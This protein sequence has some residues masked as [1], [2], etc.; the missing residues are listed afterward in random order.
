MKYLA[1]I[2]ARCSSHRLPSKV[3]K[4]LCGKSVLERVVERVQ[5]SE[6]IDEVM[7]VTSLNKE[8]LQ[9]VKTMSNKDVRVFAGSLD[10]VLDRYYQ[11][12][13][14]INPEYVIRITADC[15]VID[16]KVID[17]AL[18]SL[19]SDTDYLGMLTETFPDG[20][21]VEI[22]KF[23]ALKTAWKK[24]KLKSEREH[25]TMYIKN[26]K[27]KF[28]VQNYECKLGNLHDQRWTV[29][30]PE[31]YEFIKN[32]YEHFISVGKEDFDLEDILE[33][34]KQNPEVEKINKGFIRNEGL[35]ISQ[36]NDCL[37]EN[38]DLM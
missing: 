17:D 16:Y 35:L 34:L 27:D 21:D 1:M 19:S 38:E 15:P 18:R 22:V 3:M 26:N 20:L 28:K 31:D 33:Y 10:D 6:L 29:D 13:K 23:E 30:E 4:D 8:D 36:N 7:V 37:V 5:K 9:I 24:A 2:Q 14:I 25:V 11:A 12:A 32:V